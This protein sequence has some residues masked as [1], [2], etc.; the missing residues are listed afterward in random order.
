MNRWSETLRLELV[1]LGV[2]TMTIIVGT[3]ESQL[4]DKAFGLNLPSTSSYRPVK[5]EM[6]KTLDY[7]MTPALKFADSVVTDVLNGKRGYLFK[8]T[9]SSILKWVLPFMPQWL[10]V[11]TSDSTLTADSNTHTL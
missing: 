5:E 7:P 2:K 4:N 9:S 3:V 8:A 6:E 11:S 10:I 1:P